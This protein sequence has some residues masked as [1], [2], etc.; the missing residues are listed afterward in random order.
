MKAIILAIGILA[1]LHGCKG[2]PIPIEMDDNHMFAN[3]TITNSTIIFNFI[4]AIAET[5]NISAPINV[6]SPGKPTE[7]PEE[8]TTVTPAWTTTVPWPETSTT[9][10]WPETSTT[11]TWIPTE[12]F[13]TT[14]FTTS[15][16]TE[17][18]TTKPFPT[19]PPS[20]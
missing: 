5:Q 13:P 3:N 18:S 15:Y 19:F 9:A 1:V 16:V 4:V 20:G 11:D 7:T 10:A 14:V 17:V 6:G 12:T 2:N 8:S